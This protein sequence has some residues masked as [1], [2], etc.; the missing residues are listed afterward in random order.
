MIKLS[1]RTSLHRILQK[2]SFMQGSV[3]TL[4]ALP[5]ICIVLTALL[6]GMTL[7]EVKQQKTEFEKHALTDAS[8]HARAFAQQMSKAFEQAD[9]ITL[10]VKQEWEQSNG[11]M[12]METLFG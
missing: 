3:S 2:L 12:Q 6:W 11:K 7:S 9:K 5:A 4:L 8:T 10:M 1:I